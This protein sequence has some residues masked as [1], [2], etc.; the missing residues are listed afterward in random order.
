MN[1]TH[2]IA[3]F[4]LSKLAAYCLALALA[5]LLQHRLDSLMMMIEH[6]KPHGCCYEFRGNIS[7]S[8]RS[9]AAA[10]GESKI[11]IIKILT[12]IVRKPTRMLII[13]IMKKK[14]QKTIDLSTNELLLL[15]LAT[16]TNGRN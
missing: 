9:S 16:K 12:Q 7:L 8:Y 15:L 5:C 2:S 6:Y 14:K 11:P 3:H 10:R 1:F 4:L 13:I